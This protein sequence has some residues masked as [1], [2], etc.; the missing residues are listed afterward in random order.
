MN[1]D[2]KLNVPLLKRLVPN[3]TVAAKLA[4]LRP[5]TVSNLCTG[6][7]PIGRAEVKTLVALATIADCTLDEL[8]I[9]ETGTEMIETGI[10][11]VDLFAPIVRGGTVGLV[12]RPGMGQLVLMGELF[13]RMKKLNYTT[14]FLLGN[15]ETQGIDD[16]V[17]H[18]DFCTSSLEE[19]L[20]KLK[21]LQAEQ[22]IILGLDRK[23]LLSGDFFDISDQL[24]KVTALPI[25]FILVDTL[26]NAVDENSPYGPLET[27]LR[28][29]MDLVSRRMYPAIDPTLSTSTIIEG[30]HIDSPHFT[31]QQR[32]RK[33][34]RRYRELRFIVLEWGIEKLTESDLN[35]YHRGQ[36]LEA[37]FTQP[38]Y[39]AESITKKQGEWIS[40]QETFDS[41]TRILDGAYD[42]VLVDNLKYIGSLH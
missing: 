17:E 12:A 8:I 10:K 13:F 16:V 5:A 37:F 23:M 25:T 14:L 34:L 33:L 11:V 7:I 26:G 20:S 41:I 3:L 39:V 36:R 30:A 15:D 31:I 2:L 9:R 6:K 24:R 28:F 42:D 21:G 35:V 22:E 38:F 29:D 19:L 27:I 4:G 40:M 32:A 18:S 1:D